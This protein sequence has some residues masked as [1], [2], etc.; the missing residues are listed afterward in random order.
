MKRKQI[1]EWQQAA[2]LLAC[3]M[4]TIECECSVC[5]SESCWAQIVYH[6]CG[7]LMTLIE[8]KRPDLKW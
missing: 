8:D 4:A 1:S 2:E 7:R 6:W 5:A 3:C